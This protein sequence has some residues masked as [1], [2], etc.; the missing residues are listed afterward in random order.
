MVILVSV[1]SVDMA[2][3]EVTLEDTVMVPLM[4]RGFHMANPMFNQFD[5]LNRY[6]SKRLFNNL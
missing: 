1:P 6:I 5:M 2:V 4:A 3:M